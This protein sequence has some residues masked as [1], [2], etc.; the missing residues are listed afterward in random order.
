MDVPITLFVLALCIVGLLAW[1]GCFRREALLA[2]PTRDAG[3]VPADLLI[4]LGLMVLGGSVAG[5]ML[6]L[7]LLGSADLDPADLPTIDQAKRVLLT[8]AMGQ[9]PVVIYLIWRVSFVPRGPWRVGV[10]SSRPGRDL[11]W[12]VLGCIV[13]VPLVM[14][15][16]QVAV[17]IGLLFGQEPPVIGHEMLRVMRDSDSLLASGLIAC[18]AVLIA[19]VL[20]EAIFRGLFQSVMAEVLGASMRWPI[21][22]I[23]AMVFSLIHVGAADWQALPGL[24][25]LGV[26]LGWLYER[27]GSLW[28]GIVVHVGFN[29]LNIAIMIIV[30]AH[31][32]ATS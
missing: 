17:M 30:T 2:G 22:L 27:S 24:F 28:P 29:A 6:R 16:I 20:E 8:Q 32:E 25:V 4:G 21:V 12:G 3:L 7:G 18:S 15:T 13:A 11:G 26:V 14:G 23:S 5:L 10:L 19:P 9:L 31:P 1:A